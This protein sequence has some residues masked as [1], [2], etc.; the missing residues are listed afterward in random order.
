MLK[1][2]GSF[3]DDPN[4]SLQPRKRP[5]TTPT[6]SHPAIPWNLN[7]DPRQ[8]LLAC[9]FHP[10]S[11]HTIQHMTCPASYEEW[12]ALA[13]TLH[14]PPK[15]A[16]LRMDP[17]VLRRFKTYAVQHCMHLGAP[18]T[19]SSLPA[20]PPSSSIQPPPSPQLQVP[21]E[22][23]A[24]AAKVIFTSSTP[25][26]PAPAPTPTP[27]P[28]VTKVV[29]IPPPM[30]SI[31][32]E[33][34]TTDPRK[35]KVAT[36]NSDHIMDDNHSSIVD[37]DGDNQWV[38]ADDDDSWVDEEQDDGDYE[39]MDLVSDEDAEEIAAG[40]STHERAV[41]APGRDKTRNAQNPDK[42]SISNSINTNT[43]N[44]Q[45]NTRRGTRGIRNGNQRN[46]NSTTTS[47]D[48]KTGNILRRL[49]TTP[50]S[51][52]PTTSHSNL[53]YKI[54]KPFQAGTCGRPNCPN[55]HVCSRCRHSSHGYE[56]C[57]VK[58]PLCANFQEGIA[59]KR[60]PCSYMHVCRKCRKDGHGSAHCPN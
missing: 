43:Q 32:P 25:K 8:R 24:P 1:R 5:S 52:S 29:F 35:P 23:L 36:E 42:T 20:I 12:E 2:K 57:V 17:I 7:W 13:R 51:T 59:C 6:S 3:A 34:S 15:L 55:L 54:C 26:A 9:P 22:P 48:G 49:S 10:A 60:K 37:D 56:N 21:S 16:M 31:H 47:D 19:Q 4:A 40:G 44:T 27:E 33:P 30:P 39:D 11:L 18:P 58:R 38:D 14:D 53:R 50:S 41:Q 45:S 46:N 28:T